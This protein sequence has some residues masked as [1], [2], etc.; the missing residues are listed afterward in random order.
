MLSIIATESSQVIENARLLE[1]EKDLISVK[2][3]LRISGQIQKR[4][5]PE[6]LPDIPGYQ[7]AAENIPAK[8][9]GGDYYDI[10]PLSDKKY[11]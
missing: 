10:I 7:V 6:K 8:E 1:E 9:V 11:A 2:E 5:L 3:E 4:L